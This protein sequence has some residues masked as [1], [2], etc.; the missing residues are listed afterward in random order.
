MEEILEDLNIADDIKEA[1]LGKRNVLNEMIELAKAV[2]YSRWD[3]IDKFLIKYK[4]NQKDFNS[5]Y[6]NAIVWTNRIIYY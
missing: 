1:L 5:S 2:E 6:V 3:E 4:I